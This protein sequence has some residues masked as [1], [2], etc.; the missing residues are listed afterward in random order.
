MGKLFGYGLA[1][2]SGDKKAIAAALGDMGQ[3]GRGG[4]RKNFRAA[5]KK[6]K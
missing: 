5:K 6:K 1:A 3:G 4:C 2:A